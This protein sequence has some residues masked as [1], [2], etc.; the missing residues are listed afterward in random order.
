MPAR[1]RMTF[2]AHI[3]SPHRQNTGAMPP[4]KAGPLSNYFTVP[5]ASLTLT[6][7]G[8]SNWRMAK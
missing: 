1:L 2:F 6:W 7:T 8:F 3:P 5:P 4:V